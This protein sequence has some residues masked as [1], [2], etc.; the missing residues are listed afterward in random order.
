MNQIT[1]GITEITS[2]ITDTTEGFKIPNLMWTGKF[3]ILF[4]FWKHRNL[5]RSLPV[6]KRNTKMLITANVKRS[7]EYY[8][9][10]FEASAALQSILDEK[11]LNKLPQRFVKNYMMASPFVS[12]A[13]T[14]IPAFIVYNS[15]SDRT[16]VKWHTTY[17]ALRM[18]SQGFRPVRLLFSVAMINNIESTV[19][20][21]RFVHFD[22]FVYRLTYH[23]S[24]PKIKRVVILM[25]A[26]LGEVFGEPYGKPIILPN[27]PLLFIVA[28]NSTN[29]VFNTMQSEAYAS[30][31]NP[32]LSHSIMNDKVNF[33]MIKDSAP[34]S[35]DCIKVS[36]ADVDT[37][38]NRKNILQKREELRLRSQV[39]ARKLRDCIRR[40]LLF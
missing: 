3:R 31:Q 12:E 23:M 27:K 10:A 1:S 21:L 11:I 32:M 30:P 14:I 19:L 35:L 4:F 38:L 24:I 15:V 18:L 26:T 36:L 37:D 16:F 25:L 8:R 20:L 28:K 7:K 29:R 9:N 34:P 5:R 33:I 40:I 6:L 2:G 13:V 22:T 39:N 17:G